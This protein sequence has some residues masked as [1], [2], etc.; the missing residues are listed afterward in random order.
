MIKLEVIDAYTKDNTI[1][2]VTPITD[3]DELLSANIRGMDLSTPYTLNLQ[4]GIN[5]RIYPLL[6]DNKNYGVKI[7]DGSIDL[8]FINFDKIKPTSDGRVDFQLSS[9]SAKL[10]NEPINIKTEYYNGSAIELLNRLSSSYKFRLV[11]PDVDVFVETGVLNNLEL[12][13]EICKRAGLWSW[14][15]NGV[16][17]VDGKQKYEILVGDF[18]DYKE[19][20]R[21]VSFNHRFKDDSDA[22]ITRL[23]PIYNTNQYNLLDIIGDTGGGGG[24][25]NSSIIFTPSDISASYINPKYPLVDIGG[26][27]YVQDTTKKQGF[28]IYRTVVKQINANTTESV[29]V[30]VKRIFSLEQAKEVLYQLALNDMVAEKSEE[31]YNIDLF[32][33]SIILPGQKA[34][35]KYKKLSEDI[36]GEQKIVVEIDDVLVFRNIDINL[37][38]L[39]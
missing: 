36:N 26:T 34:I 16:V 23:S 9:Y 31:E 7:T 27:V 20:Y 22:I 19:P 24:S 25:K 4:F 13:D 14:R 28:N 1:E 6:R 18:D 5:S 30:N 12:L 10:K 15:D 17:T 21:K 32:Y 33:K 3:R 2:L 29:G 35:I 39:L 38:D 8:V 11:S 37:N